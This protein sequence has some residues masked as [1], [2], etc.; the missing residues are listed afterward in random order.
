MTENRC[1]LDWLLSLAHAVSQ[2]FELAGSKYAVFITKNK[3]SLWREA[4]RH[5]QSL[6]PVS[7]K[8][9]LSMLAAALFLIEVATTFTVILHCHHLCAVL[10]RINICCALSIFRTLIF[11]LYC[12]QKT[13]DYCLWNTLVPIAW[14]LDKKKMYIAHSQLPGCRALMRL[15]HVVSQEITDLRLWNTL[16]ECLDTK[17]MYIA[18]SQL[19]GCR[20]LMRLKF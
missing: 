16:P 18:H 11:V 19:P 4:C 10:K 9:V 1:V 7:C 13:T 5:A 12:I 8:F 3:H 20:A 17:K 14:C 15:A 2:C 6:T